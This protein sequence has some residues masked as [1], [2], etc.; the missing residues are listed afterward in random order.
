MQWFIDKYECYIV[1]W[2]GYS[3]ATRIEDGAVWLGGFFFGIIIMALLAGYFMLRLHS[4]SNYGKNQLRLLRVD[5]GKTSTEIIS[6]KNLWE[7]FEQVLLLSFSPF[8][9]IQRFTSRDAQRTKRFVRI[10][11]IVVIIVLLYSLL[12]IVSVLQSV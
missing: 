1:K 12:A 3:A 5:H 10:M 6:K 2:F 8:F 7:T 11:A 9:T 4:L